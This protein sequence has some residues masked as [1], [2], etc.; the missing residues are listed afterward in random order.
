MGD[1]DLKI[2]KHSLTLRG[3]VEDK[4]RMAIRSGHFKQGQRLVER[5][6]CELLD[7]SRTSVREAL[8][9][10]EAEGLISVIPHK[11]P[12]VTIMK[13]EDAKQ[14]YELRALLEGYAGEKFAETGPDELKDKLSEAI[15]NFEAISKSGTSNELL[16]AKAGFYELLLE[17]SGNIFVRQTLEGLYNRIALLRM[18]SMSQP[19]RLSHSLEELRE[20]VSAIQANDGPAAREACRRHIQNAATAALSGMAKSEDD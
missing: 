6:L 20:I 10:L 2:S 3:L 1:I 12:I 7:V 8:R 15:S 9:H 5:E 13:R 14:L 19:G 18:T 17:G 11:G 16:D 4:I